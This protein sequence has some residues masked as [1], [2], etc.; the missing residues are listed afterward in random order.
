MA[1]LDQRWCCLSCN[2]TMR[3]GEMKLGSLTSFICPKCDSDDTYP[4]EGVVE[5]EEYHGE[6]PPMSERS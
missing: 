4:A 1:D 3:L 2:A 6:L 5:L